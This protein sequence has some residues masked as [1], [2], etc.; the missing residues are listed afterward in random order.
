[1]TVPRMG[2]YRVGCMKTLLRARCL[3]F[4]IRPLT[5]FLASL[6]LH[7][8]WYQLVLESPRWLRLWRICP[9]VNQNAQF[10]YSMRIR[11]TDTMHC[12]TACAAKYW[13][14]RMLGPRTGMKK[15]PKKPRLCI[16]HV[17]VSWIYPM[18]S[19]LPKLKCSCVVH[20]R[21]CRWPAK[22]SWNKVCLRNR[23]IMRSL[24]RICGHR[25][26]PSCATSATNCDAY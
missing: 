25:I 24:D 13:R 4:P 21:L 7:W 5:L 19:Y 14:C 10:G 2:G 12:M 23:F 26:L 3:M 8:C 1:S 16:R 9:V 18:W 11:P 15:A 6:S 22:H 17:Q 20:Y